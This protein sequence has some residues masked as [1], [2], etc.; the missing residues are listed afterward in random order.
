[1]MIMC[2]I[3][4]SSHVYRGLELNDFPAIPVRRIEMQFLKLKKNGYTGCPTIERHYVL[5]Q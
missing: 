1:M 3:H 5:N 4:N 2:L